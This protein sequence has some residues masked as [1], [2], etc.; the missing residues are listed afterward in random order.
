M[1]I[2]GIDPGL[3]ICGYSVIDVSCHDESRYNVVDSGSIQTSKTHSDSERLLEI[4]NDLNELLAHYKPDVAVVE[5][6]FFFKNAKTIIPVCE[7]RGVILLT[8]K[9]HD[10]KVYEYTPLEVKQ[11]IT[12][13]GR[14]DKN[15]IKQMIRIILQNECIPKLD[16]VTDAIAIAI[17]HDRL[18][19]VT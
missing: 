16:D 6:L 19:S 1:R 9:M 13:Y 4:H 18:C 7:A 14:A 15:D 10:V 5:K 12:G 8:L 3:A 17:C 11:T 2:F